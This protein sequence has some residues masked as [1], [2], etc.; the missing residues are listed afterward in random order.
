MGRPLMTFAAMALG[1]ALTLGDVAT[2]AE[3]SNPVQVWPPGGLNQARPGTPIIVLPQTPTAPT[4]P[5][6]PNSGTAPAPVLPTLSPPRWSLTPPAEW[7]RQPLPAT[8]TPPVNAAPD[9]WARQ[10][11]PPVPTPP[12]NAPLG[13]GMGFGMGASPVQIPAASNESATSQRTGPLRTTSYMESRRQSST[14]TR[15]LQQSRSLGNFSP[16]DRRA[17]PAV[18]G[19][20][21]NSAMMYPRQS[22]GNLPRMITPNSS[23]PY[24]GT[25]S[26]RSTGNAYRTVMPG[27][28]MSSGAS[29][30]R[31]MGNL[32]PSAPVSSAVPSPPAIRR[33]SM[34]N[35]SP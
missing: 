17:F 9:E 31:S 22:M 28:S 7:G 10:P 25:Y 4:A 35:L 3:R 32:G 26:R 23:S 20:A 11:L 34:G 21:P 2:S 15:N 12:A 27:T 14:R 18:R 1:A 5:T 19:A 24:Q 8:P 13:M 30:R 33:R 29:G 6:A 16:M